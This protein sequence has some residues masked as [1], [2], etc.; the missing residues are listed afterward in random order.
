MPQYKLYYFDL[1]GRA[2]VIRMLF[3]IAGQKYED[4]RFTL[5]KWPE[6]K[7]KAP[8]GQCPYL[9]VIDGENTLLLAQSAAISN[10]LTL[11]M[12]HRLCE[13]FIDYIACL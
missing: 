2:E 3:A 1:K 6:Y 13:L 4:I 5:D 9:E 7:A 8:F 12:F 10:F 11:K